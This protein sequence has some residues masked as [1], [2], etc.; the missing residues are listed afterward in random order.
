MDQVAQLLGT[1]LYVDLVNFGLS[2]H[3][4]R[5]KNTQ[6]VPGNS[7]NLRQPGNPP[8]KE[9]AII[10]DSEGSLPLLRRGQFKVLFQN[11]FDLTDTV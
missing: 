2:Q 7:V 11:A 6:G 3:F 10:D 9:A 5:N 1:K 8:D 4:C